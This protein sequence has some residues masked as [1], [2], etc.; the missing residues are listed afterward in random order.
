MILNDNFILIERLVFYE[1]KYNEYI[2]L[3]NS[4]LKTLRN[5]QDLEE[6]FYKHFLI[7]K[8]NIL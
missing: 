7:V 3:H 6:Y 4:K 1:K 8:D 2:I 5:S